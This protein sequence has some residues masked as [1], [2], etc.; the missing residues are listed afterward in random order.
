MIFPGYSGLCSRP[1]KWVAL[2]VAA[3]SAADSR[4]A[5]AQPA[6][7]R[8][9]VAVLAVEGVEPATADSLTELVIGAVAAR[10]NTTLVGKEELQAQLGQSETGSIDCVGSAACLGRIGVQLRVDELIA[11]T[12][13]RNESSWTFNLNRI[14]IRSGEVIGRAFREVNGDLGAVADA[15]VA[16]VPELY[17]VVVSPG[18]LRIVAPIEGAEV[19]VDEVLIGTVGRAGTTLTVSDVVPGTHVVVVQAEGYEPWQRTVRVESASIHEVEP[20]LVPLTTSGVGWTFVWIGGAVTVAAA[21]TAVFFGLASQEEPGAGA[22]RLEAIERADQ[23]ETDATIANVALGVGGAGLAV[24]MLGL[25]LVA[26]ETSEP[27]L[28][29]TVSASSTE[30]HLGFRGNF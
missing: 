2:I 19:L 10:G 11:G 30:I 9:A 4:P 21:G 27:V 1:M 22:T 20:H 14:D 26:G 18:T 7:L 6:P 29:P 15:V 16:A 23:A 28:E 12:I 5:F 13:G 24:A 25:V 8:V 17:A 3:F